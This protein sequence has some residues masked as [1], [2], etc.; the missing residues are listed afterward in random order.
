MEIAP[1]CLTYPATD[2]QLELCEKTISYINWSNSLFV[3]II[4]SH[5]GDHRIISN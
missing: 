4:E 2:N 5:Q 3:K 1:K